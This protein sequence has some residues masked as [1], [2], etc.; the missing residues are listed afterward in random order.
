MK[1]MLSFPFPLMACIMVAFAGL[2]E[3]WCIEK[4][5]GI[6]GSVD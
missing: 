4:V 6:F 1:K 3:P 2:R 5:G